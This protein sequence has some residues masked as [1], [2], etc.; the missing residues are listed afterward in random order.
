MTC[1]LWLPPQLQISLESLIRRRKPGYSLEQAFYTSPEIFQADLDI[2]F[3][4]HWIYVGVEPDVPE[5]G[6]CMVVDIDRASI[7]IARDDDMGLRAFHNV[8]R[9][10][11]ARL[12]HDE[13]TTVG[14]IVC[15]YHQWTY[16]LDGSLLYAEHMGPGFDTTCHGLKKVHV[17]SVAGL[18]FI[19]LAEDPPADIDDM[20]RALEPYIAPHDIANAKVVQQIDLIEEGNWKLT[21]ENNRECYHCSVNHPELTVP[22]FAYGFGYSPDEVDDVGREQIA[23]Y[24]RLV[25]DL[26]ARCEANGLA[27]REID[28]LDDCVTGYRAQRLPIDQ[29]GESQTMNTAGRLQEAARQ[30]QRPE[31][32]RACRSGPSPIPGTTS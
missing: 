16:G 24:D 27:A 6:D 12:V 15:R 21:M 1:R 29:H 11:G 30:H 28:H 23:R 17:R 31:A 25:C 19:C 26:E 9:H 13:K 4:R 14:N 20:A 10:R 22:L 32:R 18:I 8:C 2:I 7:I 5:P 3:R